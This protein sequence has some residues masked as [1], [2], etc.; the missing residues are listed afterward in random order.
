MVNLKFAIGVIVGVAVNPQALDHT[1]V[2]CGKN[3]AYDDDE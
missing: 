3:V 2:L 1:I